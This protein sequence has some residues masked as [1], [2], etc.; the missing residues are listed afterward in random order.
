MATEQK[1]TNPY[2]YALSCIKGKWK[3][4]ILHQIH[5]LGKIRF[6]QTLNRFPISEKVLSQQLKELIADGLIERIQYNTVPLKVEYILTP[7]GEDLIPALD[8]LYVWGMRRMSDLDIEIDPDN[9]DV[10][11]D[12]K[13]IDQ[14]EDIFRVYERQQELKL[15]ER[16]KLEEANAVFIDEKKE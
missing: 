9:F 3:M 14:L 2:Q 15:Y 16:Q 8:I 11:T 5:H 7:A 10:H 12:R 6:N 4:S 13:Y 1:G